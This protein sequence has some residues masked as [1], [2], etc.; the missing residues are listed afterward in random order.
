M[1]AMKETK[2]DFTKGSVASNILR[3]AIPMTIAQIVNVLYN[4]V[5]RM[6]IGRLPGEGCSP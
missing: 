4:I 5:D 1:D 2:N 3:M 6:F